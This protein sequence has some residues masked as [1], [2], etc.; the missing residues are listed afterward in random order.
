MDTAISFNTRQSYNGKKK[1][2][3]KL[4]Q[5][6]KRKVEVK[7]EREE[8]NGKENRK[9]AQEPARPGITTTHLTAQKGARETTQVQVY[10]HAPGADQ[11]LPVHLFPQYMIIASRS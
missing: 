1:P 2:E 11:E 4:R 6:D 7:G 8:V 3:Q 9:E 10:N 5:R